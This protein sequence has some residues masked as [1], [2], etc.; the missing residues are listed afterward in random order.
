MSVLEPP[1]RCC[2]APA[3]SGQIQGQ[4]RSGSRCPVSIPPTGSCAAAPRRRPST[5]FRSRITT[6]PGVIDAVGAGVSQERLGQRV[7]TWLAAA[8]WRWGTAAEWTVIP[9]RQA[10]PLPEGVSPEL[11][12]SLGV[13]AMTAYW[14]LYADGPLTG[15][16]VLI[17]GGAGRSKAFAIELAKHGGAQVIATVSGPA[18]AKLA[19]RAGAD[20][21]VNYR[22]V[23]AAE[24]IASFAGAVDR[25]IEVALGANV[26]LDLAVASPGTRITT[27]A[28]EASD[29]VL[30]PVRAC[31]TAN[32]TMKLHAGQAVRQAL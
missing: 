31:M 5:V 17:A 14:C 11:G 6:T 20:L 4:V 12:A 26:K 28:A 15:Q 19:A 30:L 1:Q 2:A 22:E 24:R 8:G 29:P 3:S 9:E 25:V 23:D 27:Y 13:P 10:V 21:V 18:E 7:W 16:T 32:V